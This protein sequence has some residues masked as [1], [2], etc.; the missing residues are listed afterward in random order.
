MPSPILQRYVRRA[1]LV[2]V[3]LFALLLVAELAA[4]VLWEKKDPLSFAKLPASAGSPALLEYDAGAG[5]RLRGNLQMQSAF[6]TI[7]STNRD[8]IRTEQQIIPKPHT[9]IRIVCYGDDS[10][11]GAGS[12]AEPYPKILEGLLRASVKYPDI[13]VINLSTPG[14]SI[15]RIEGRIKETI[16]ALRPDFVIV[17]S[18]A[19]DVAVE[20]VRDSKL[21]NAGAYEQL[22]RRWAEISRLANHLLEKLESSRAHDPL[23]ACGLRRVSNEDYL[24]CALRLRDFC[25]KAGADFR[26]LTA[27]YRQPPKDTATL[28]Q[29]STADYAQRIRE[30]GVWHNV[31]MQDPFGT[32]ENAEAAF[33]SEDPPLLSRAGHEVVAKALLDAMRL[34]VWNRVNE[35]AEAY[36]REMKALDY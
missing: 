19:N 11:F 29:K 8:G 18:F 14:Y 21:A 33:L 28:A 5:W 15:L 36:P 30:L 25:R 23:D 34:R 4:R 35:L 16:A 6:N 31:E 26:M 7:F 3:C 9:R 13:E 1:I 2:G 17:Q 32:G 22:L 27:F 12:V 20:G 10:G 24:A